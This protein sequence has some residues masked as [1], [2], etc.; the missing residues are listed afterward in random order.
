M[1]KYKLLFFLLSIFFALNTTSVAQSVSTNGPTD[2]LTVGERFNFALKVQSDKQYDKI[3]FP[4]STFFTNHIEFVERKQFRVSNFADSVNYSLQFF[5]NKDINIAP[6]PVQIVAGK[7]T[8]TLFTSVYPL[9]F[10]SVITEQTEDFAPLKPIFDFAMIIWPWVLAALLLGVVAYFLYRKYRKKPE[11]VEEV[12]V[13]VPVFINPLQTLEQRLSEIKHEHS[14]RIEK[15]YKHF[16]SELGDSIRLYLE[17]VYSIP[18]LESTTRELM[19]YL[20]AFGVDLELASETR[21]ILTEADMIKFAKT[22]P[23]LDQSWQA[24]QR[25]LTFY[26]RAKSYDIQRIA[27]LKERFEAQFKKPETDSEERVDDLG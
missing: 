9:H 19:R 21:A 2:S 24:F 10:K 4:D 23:T 12:E 20:E 3:I 27:R 26:E 22:T 11:V 14:N 18:A 13:K 15:D 17:E 5:A 1:T 25:G 16:Y 6:L 7:D 8:T